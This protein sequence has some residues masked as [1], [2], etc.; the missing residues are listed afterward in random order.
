MDF[1]LLSFKIYRQWVKIL[2]SGM[3]EFNEPF[4]LNSFASNSMCKVT[5]LTNSRI[6]VGSK[7]LGLGHPYI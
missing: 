4:K 7:Y 5:N 6:L 1:S 2:K 3:I